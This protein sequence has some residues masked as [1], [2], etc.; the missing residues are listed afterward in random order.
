MMPRL[1]TPFQSC[2]NLLEVYPITLIELPVNRGKKGALSAGVLRA[3]GSIVAFADSDTVWARDAVEMAVPIFLGNPD[4]GA[5]SGHC[6]ALNADNNLLT[7]IQDSWYEG[8]YSV[9][10]AF[11]SVF[12]CGDLRLRAAGLL[13]AVGYLQFHAG[14]GI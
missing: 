7:K 11:E 5:V 9:R 3:H 1:T 2:A 12:G 4:V 6:R 13:P 14:L 10:K 8:Q